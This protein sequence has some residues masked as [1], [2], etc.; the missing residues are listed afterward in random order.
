MFI[1][2]DNA[3]LFHEIL[4]FYLNK[5]YKVECN[6]EPL[7]IHLFIKDDKIITFTNIY[8]DLSNTI[9]DLR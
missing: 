9:I 7:D 8:T 1:I 5:K 6:I 2:T 4:S 3:E